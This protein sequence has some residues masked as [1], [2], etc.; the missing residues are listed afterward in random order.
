MAT[1][2]QRSGQGFIGLMCGATLG[3]CVEVLLGLVIASWPFN[4]LFTSLA[5]ISMVLQASYWQR[6]YREPGLM[7]QGMVGGLML[8]G[9]LWL[10]YFHV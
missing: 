1:L 6:M 3:Y 2:M 5:V 4:P 10:F 9:A 8:M 7:R